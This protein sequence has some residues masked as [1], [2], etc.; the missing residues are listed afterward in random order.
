MSICTKKDKTVWGNRNKDR[1]SFSDSSMVI[2]VIPSQKKTVTSYIE[3]YAI[4]IAHS[5]GKEKGVK[6]CWKVKLW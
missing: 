6:P 5:V 4:G 1:K 3:W 2:W